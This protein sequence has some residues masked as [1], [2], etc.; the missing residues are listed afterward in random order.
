M[1]AYTHY[2]GSFIGSSSNELHYQK[3]E[4]DS[5]V[6]NLLI[7]HG[8]GEHSGRYG[9]IIKKLEGK[10]VS[11]Y[12]FDHR[13]HGKSMGKRGHIDSFNDYVNDLKIYIEHIK[14]INDKL[15]LVMLGHSLGGVIAMKYALEYPK[16]VSALIL[17][18][19]GLIPAFTIPEWRKAMA[20]ILNIVAPGLLQSNGLNSADLS[21]DQKVIQDYNNDPLVH[22]RISVRFFI[23][24]TAAEDECLRRALEL[25]MPL[26]VFH[27]TDDKI[28]TYLGSQ[29]VY[30]RASS[31]DK[32]IYLFKN[33]YHETMNEIN[34]DDVLKA[35]VPW[36][37]DRAR[38][39]PPK[40]QTA[41][42][43]KERTP[44][45]KKGQAKNNKSQSKSS[46]RKKALKN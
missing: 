24:F 27:G 7:V 14:L 16:D 44:R 18:S 33:M 15:P 21:H 34:K 36:I 8:L 39:K 46:A 25:S 43:Q 12:S 13:G 9:N 41:A 20:G 6:L 4:A 22:D 29:Q 37:L 28:V 5:P 38:K 40:G 17:S 19:A 11:I 42:K 3:W 2:T 23:E 32:K 1:S 30:D 45:E 26:L 10:N 31:S 35:V